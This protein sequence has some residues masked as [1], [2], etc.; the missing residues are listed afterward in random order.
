MR[1]KSTPF[2]RFLL[3]GRLPVRKIVKHIINL[4]RCC[5]QGVLDLF[6]ELF[7][8]VFK[9][10]LEMEHVDKVPVKYAGASVQ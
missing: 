1:K 2:L 5:L 8:S 3:R 7:P 9:R 6:L 10:E 4:A